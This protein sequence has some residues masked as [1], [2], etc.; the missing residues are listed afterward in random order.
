MNE[1]KKMKDNIEFSSAH[2]TGVCN[3]LMEL[4]NIT[5]ISGS[6][7][8]AIE[9]FK[10]LFGKHFDNIYADKIG[11]IIMVKKC[12]KENAKR[13]LLDAHLDTIGLMVT[14]VY[15]DG[16]VSVC[17]IGGIDTRILPASEVTIYGSEQIYGVVV[18]TP[19]HLSTGSSVPKM[20]SILIDTGI[21]DESIKEK[22]HVGDYVKIRGDF[23]VVNDYAFS[24]GLDDRACLCSC[25][26][27]VINANNLEYDV[28]VVASC[29]EETGAFGARTALFDIE[30]DIAIATDVNFGRE[31]GVEKRYSIECKKGPSIDL[32][33]I[34]DR[35]LSNAII[36]IAKRNEIPYQIVVEAGRTGTNA[37]YF[38]ITGKGTRL[39]L[40]SLPLKG[41]H[42]PSECV[43]LEDIC[44]LSKILTKVIESKERELWN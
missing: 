16:F 24:A 23:M 2:M 33:V 17:S 29:M 8:N 41:M 3:T 31:P 12:G 30:P 28:Y 6:E 21:N 34:L 26:D 15:D 13:L 42:T 11:N 38:S 18:S 39:A 22:I 44:S 27:A 7:C 19:P 1:N 5:A 40:M 10:G 20:E 32:S 43:S 36:E 35:E 9:S 25:I 14:G 37:D 4:C